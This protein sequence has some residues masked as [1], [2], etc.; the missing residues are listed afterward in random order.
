[1]KYSSGSPYMRARRRKLLGVGIV[2][3]VGVLLL[4]LTNVALSR[5]SSSKNSG[6]SIVSNTAKTD[7]TP[8]ADADRRANRSSVISNLLPHEEN[9]ATIVAATNND[10]VTTT[11]VAPLPSTRPIAILHT[12]HGDITW[13]LLPEDAPKT[14]ANIVRMSHEGVFNK[15]CFYRYEQGFVLQGGLHC[16]K[17]PPHHGR[18]KNVPLEYKRRNEKYTVALARAG[19]DLN[20]G[21]TEFFINLRDNSGT[22]G[23]GKKGGYAVFATVVDGL[24]TI[25]ALKKLPTKAGG[26]TRFVSPQPVIEYIE[27]RNYHPSEDSEEEKEGLKNKSHADG[28]TPHAT[29][30]PQAKKKSHQAATHKNSE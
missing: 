5:S 3:G 23:P 25:A 18:A 1:M 24:D 13:E 10:A 27:I 7:E 30:K 14:V 26:L 22:L 21:G 17:P 9:L 20:S 4:L 28:N 12:D 2:V 8:L 6:V 11:T 16:N 19:G 29:K 15:S